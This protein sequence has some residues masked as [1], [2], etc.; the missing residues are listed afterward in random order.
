MTSTEYFAAIAAWKASYAA[1]TLETQQTK[2]SLRAACQDFAKE[3][4]AVK[5]TPYGEVC[6]HEAPDSYK[7]ALNKLAKLQNERRSLRA[8]AST[9]LEARQVLKAEAHAFWHANKN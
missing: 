7:A 2:T 5:K 4:A 9:L 3:R 8:I 6:W 1:H